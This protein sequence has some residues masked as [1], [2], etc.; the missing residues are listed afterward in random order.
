MS[1]IDQVSDKNTIWCFQS[2]PAASF[3]KR[4][5]DIEWARQ[6]GWVTGAPTAGR[7]NTHF[8]NV[9]GTELVLREYLRGG[10]VRHVNPR[11][12]W[13]RG[14]QHTRAFRELHMLNNCVSKGLPTPVG[15]ACKIERHGLVYTA[16]L[17]THK[18]A[19]VTFAEALDNGNKSGSTIGNQVEGVWQSIGKTIAR[20]H[21]AGIWHA[22]LNAHNILVSDDAEISLIDF[23]RAREISPNAP[24]MQSNISRLHRSLIKEAGKGAYSVDVAGWAA[25]LKAYEASSGSSKFK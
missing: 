14:L 18:L 15:Y 24:S 7:G 16:S 3:N 10:L 11:Y 2:E 20:F 23:D 5:F 21:N 9:D 6:Q 13:W 1:K 25:L 4:L 19:G 12:Y 17:I 8:L 22:D